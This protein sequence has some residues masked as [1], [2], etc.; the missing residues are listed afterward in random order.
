MEGKDKVKKEKRKLGGY[1]ASTT[2][3]MFR[4]PQG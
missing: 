1:G 3:G 4:L 2:T